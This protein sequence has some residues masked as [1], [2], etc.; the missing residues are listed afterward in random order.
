MVRGDAFE[1]FRLDV[2]LT[3]M[4]LALE[5]VDVKRAALVI[6][7][8]SSRPSRILSPRASPVNRMRF[9]STSASTTM[10]D[11]FATDLSTYAASASAAALL[12]A[13]YLAA[14]PRVSVEAP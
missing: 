10:L 6:K 14:T 3:T 7:P 13:G 11:R 4:M 1:E 5:H 2:V 8:T 9:V 12:P